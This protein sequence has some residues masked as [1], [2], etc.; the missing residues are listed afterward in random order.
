MAFAKETRCRCVTLDGDVFDP[1]GTVTGGSKPSNSGLLL[2]MAEL[3]RLRAQL[4]QAEDAQSKL[5]SQLEA[6][7]GAAEKQATLQRQQDLAAHKAE[8]TRARMQQGASAQ[9]IRE[10]ER[11]ESE[12]EQLEAAKE[13]AKAD[14]RAAKQQYAAL[15]KQMASAEKTKSE[16]TKEIQVRVY[17]CH[18]EGSR[19]GCLWAAVIAEP[20]LVVVVLI[21]SPLCVVDTCCVICTR[22]D[23]RDGVYM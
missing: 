21:G 8:I 4:A 20:L 15:E 19:G 10:C 6:V 9:S 1:S 7:R 23:S 18:G 22:V 16:G 17:V 2:H 13:A 12:I 11:M 14:E 3:A 5:E